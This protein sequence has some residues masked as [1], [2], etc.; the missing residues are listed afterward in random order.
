[1][2]WSYV[3]TAVGVTG[4]WL[5]GK[6]VW[7]AWW[8]GVSAQVLWVAYAIA[9]RQWGFIISALAYGTVQGKNAIEWTREH[10]AHAD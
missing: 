2:L 10:R 8:I 3:L 9:T 6:K 1:M 5:I 4:M 7:W